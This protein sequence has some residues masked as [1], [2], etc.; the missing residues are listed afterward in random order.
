MLKNINNQ[1]GDILGF[2]IVSPFAIW[3]IT[4]LIFAGTFQLD[5]IQM[6]SIVNKTLDMALVEGQYENDLQQVLKDEL[7]SSGFTEENLKINISPNEA[8]DAN[9]ATYVK[10][11]NI[12]EITVI[13]EKPHI[14]Y[15]INFKIGG[16]NKYYIATST[17]GM[18]EK[19]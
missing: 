10:R 1:K 15:Y 9:N 14:F 12:V 18:S 8:G 4:W 6:D 16:E 3:I 7:I 11:G 19:W 13:H 2:I 17:K 5:K